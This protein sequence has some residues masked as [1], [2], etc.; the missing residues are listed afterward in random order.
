VN[1][2]AATVG[3]VVSGIDSVLETQTKG[4]KVRCKTSISLSAPLQ[5]IDESMVY[6]NDHMPGRGSGKAPG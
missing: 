3:G 5:C 6:G 1:G 4:V 2:R